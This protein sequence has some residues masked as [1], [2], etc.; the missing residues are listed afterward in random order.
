MKS[1][2][3]KAA[4]LL[5]RQV[6]LVLAVLVFFGS[7]PVMALDGDFTLDGSYAVFELENGQTT[8]SVSDKIE[9]YG[10]SGYVTGLNNVGSS[11]SFDVNVTKTGIYG[12]SLR[13]ALYVENQALGKTQS[14]NPGSTYG[15][16]TDGNPERGSYWYSGVP[17]NPENPKR[18]MLDLG[19]VMPVHMV[20]IR[21]VTDWGARTQTFRI[22]GSV[23]NENFFTL[24]DTATYQFTPKGRGD[25]SGNY[26]D[27]YFEMTDVRYIRLVFT[28]ISDTG[29]NGAQVGEFEVY[30]LFSPLEPLEKMHEYVSIEV[31]GNESDKKSV[32]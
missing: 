26:A 16:V 27:A 4:I 10:G 32:Q 18:L 7:V 9:G 1:L 11:V 12:L 21:V 15:N 2:R 19:M 25:F 3:K 24:K 13:S 29:T 6:C 5:R 23:D 14:G 28:Q 31:G 17:V 20:R 30:T 8:G 22:E